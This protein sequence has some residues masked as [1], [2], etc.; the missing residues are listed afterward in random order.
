VTKTSE[1][2]ASRETI[3]IIDS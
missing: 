1:G 2:I 3:R